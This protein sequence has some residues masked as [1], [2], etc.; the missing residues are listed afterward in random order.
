MHYST[1]PLQSWADRNF[2]LYAIQ[3]DGQNL[4]HASPE[5]KA[6]REIAL[7]A[8]KRSGSALTF[9]DQDLKTDLNF[10][11]QAVIANPKA[12]ERAVPLKYD[13]SVVK[14]AIGQNSEGFPGCS[15][16]CHR[17]LR[18]DGEI[19][20]LYNER[21]ANELRQDVR[22]CT[23]SVCMLSKAAASLKGIWAR[24]PLRGYGHGFP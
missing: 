15:L 18:N 7:T 24:L 13:R 3:A 1:A 10:V 12:M 6:D 8:V 16:M 17:N 19:Y 9:V 2:V 21:R 23:D 20:R 11:L 5:L 14:K 4:R 22:G